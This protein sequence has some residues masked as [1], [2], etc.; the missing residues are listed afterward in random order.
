M[1]LCCPIIF[2]SELQNMISSDSLETNKDCDDKDIQFTKNSNTVNHNA[3]RKK[4]IDQR[5]QAKELLAKSI[6]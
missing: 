5:I 6:F 1:N 2:I 3:D 4:E